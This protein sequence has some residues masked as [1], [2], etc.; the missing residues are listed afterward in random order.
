MGVDK[1]MLK[2]KIFLRQ[3]CGRLAYN[4]S[5][6]VDDEALENMY[7]LWRETDPY[8]A[9]MYIEKKEIGPIPS[10]H[11]VGPMMSLFNACMDQMRVHRPSYTAVPETASASHHTLRDICGEQLGSQAVAGDLGYFGM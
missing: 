11:N 1:G 9:E 8:I 3:A 10:T 2:L 7:D 5:P 4:I 6:V